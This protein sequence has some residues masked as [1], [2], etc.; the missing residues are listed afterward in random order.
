MM[1]SATQG[2]RY[3]DLHPDGNRVAIAPMP[4]I[5]AAIKQDKLVFVF[6]FFDQLR[7]IAPSANR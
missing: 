1:R 5:Q 4:E 6:N 2:Q 3:F 7:R